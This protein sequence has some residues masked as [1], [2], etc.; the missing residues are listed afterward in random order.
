VFPAVVRGA[1]VPA[2]DEPPPAAVVADEPAEEPQKAV[3]GFTGVPG[4]FELTVAGLPE[5]PQ[6]KYYVQLPPEYDPYRRYPCVVTLNGAG[7]TPQQQIDWWAGAYSKQ[8]Q[9]RFGQATRHGYI[10]V[11]P[12]W[13]REHQREYE[14]SAREHAAVLFSLRDAMKRFSIDTDRVFLNGHSMGGDAA[15]DIGIAHPDL[16]A[17]VIPIV[18]KPDKYVVR[19]WENARDVPLYFVAG[20]RDFGNQRFEAAAREWDRYLPK[21][22]FDTMVVMYQGRGHEHF[23]DEIQNIF[24]WM[25]LHKRNFFPRDFTVVSM[26][27]WDSF[28][29]WVEASN[30]PAPVL[31]AAW[32]TRATPARTTAKVLPTNGVIVTSGAQKVTVWLSPEIVD[33]GREMTLTIN[34]RRQSNARVQPSIVT[35]LE[36]VRTRGDRQH[37]F[38]AKVEN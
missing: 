15:W 27:P 22:G 17:G 24:D 6:I 25:N 36:D 28:F 10:V 29:W 33:F 35:L 16:W 21:V 1:A 14:Y 4:N 18:A 20:E 30:L 8:A 5:D 9:S 7:T 11:A 13:T 12:Q 26:R 23:H 34:R 19:Y 2:G 3:A 37:P 31:P 32:G 38:W